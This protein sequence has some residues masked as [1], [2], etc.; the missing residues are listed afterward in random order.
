MTDLRDVIDGGLHAAQ[1]RR[2]DVQQLQHVVGQ[3]VDLIRHT[4]Q[5]LGGVRF[6]L[7]QGLLLILSLERDTERKTQTFTSHTHTHMPLAS[8]PVFSH[9]NTAMLWI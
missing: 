8:S 1:L 3:S 2:L 6:S 7:L 9:I 4:G 5:R